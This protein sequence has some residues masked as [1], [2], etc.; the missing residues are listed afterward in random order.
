MP[1]HT[2]TSGAYVMDAVRGIMHAHLI[3]PD[4]NGT[5]A[6][7]PSSDAAV[8]S[9]SLPVPPCQCP[10]VD[11]L[12][13]G[14]KGVVDAK[15][16]GRELLLLTTQALSRLAATNSALLHAYLFAA[17]PAD[18]TPSLAT[19]NV[20]ASG[21]SSDSLSGGRLMCELEAIWRELHKRLCTYAADATSVCAAVD[22]VQS[23][24][25]RSD[26][27]AALLAS[28]RDLVVNFVMFQEL[29]REL[30]AIL[31]GH[32]EVAVHLAV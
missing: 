22:A 7:A 19:A 23:G 2:P 4:N 27:V 8:S 20:S 17:Q 18:T 31:E 9:A 1:T 24:A 32:A 12:I 10:A 3:E 21:G 13:A 5:I 16:R 15:D 30:G 11:A 6:T 25:G 29:L 14:L 26:A 28:K